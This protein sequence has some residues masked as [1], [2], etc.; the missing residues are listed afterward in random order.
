SFDVDPTEAGERLDRLAARRLETSRSVVQ[1]II[2]KGLL[3]VDGE[4][5]VPSYRVRGGERVEARISEEGVSPEE[6]PVSVVFEDEHLLVVEKPAGLVVHPGA[7]N[8][9]GTLVNALLG[10]GIAGGEDPSRPGVV[11]RLDRDTSGLMVL[12][13]G[14]PAYSRLVAE[15]GGRRVRRVYRAV[16][17]G[18]GLPE[19]GTV[20]SPVGR[21]P[22]NPTLM[23][24]GVGRPAVTH[25]DVLREGGG[26]SM[27]KVRLETGR[28]HQ[29]R[30]HLSAIGYPIYADPLYGEAVPGRRL[31]LHAEN[32]AFEHPVTEEKLEFDSSIPEELRDSALALDASLALW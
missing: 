23:A 27:L 10:R 6:I 16:V 11:H 1:R 20:D 24:A 31:W 19:T 15:M 12:A 21:D 17:V 14:E 29:I 7:G 28:T 18:E 2:Q 26:H 5:V 32:L 9:S 25:F 13:K 30:V 3:R 4:E 22:E 8:P